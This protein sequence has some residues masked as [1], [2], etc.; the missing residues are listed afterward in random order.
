MQLRQIAG[1]FL[2]V[3]AA[4]LC[5]RA[6]AAGTEEFRDTEWSAANYAQ[7][8]S[9][10]EPLSDKC[11]VYF[12]WVNG[13]EDFY[14]AGD[15]EQLNQAPKRLA[16][17]KTASHEV[18]IRLGPE[19]AHSYN[20]A[21]ILD[22]HWHMNAHGSISEFVTTR[23]NG[24]G[25]ARRADHDDLNRRQHRAKED[26]DSR[27]SNRRGCQRENSKC[28]PGTGEHRGDGP[29]RGLVGAG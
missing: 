6:W 12:R 11:R 13:N 1:I 27:W 18:L 22:C 8:P 17:I 5:R 9:P 23:A 21:R 28:A 20:S 19:K 26:Q 29:R 7:W 14:F 2:C 10:F 15:A 4:A 24:E 3:L 16:A 25:L